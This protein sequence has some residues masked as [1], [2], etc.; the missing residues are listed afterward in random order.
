M[1]RE[2]ITISDSGIVNVPTNTQ[3]KDF[4]IANLLGVMIPTVRG[5]IKRLLNSR[6]GV[7]CSGGIVSGNSIIPEFFGL[8][9]VIAIAFQ[10]DSYQANIF[11]RWVMRRVLQRDAQPI[12]ISMNDMRA[13]IYN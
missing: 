7:D 10:V 12:Y 13:D 3:M 6:M 9:V 5:A 4:E 1:K 2:I 11:R 8:E